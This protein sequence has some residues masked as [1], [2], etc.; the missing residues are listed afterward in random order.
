MDMFFV[1]NGIIENLYFRFLLFVYK[2][3][4][5]LFFFFYWFVLMKFYLICNI[6]FFVFIKYCFLIC[7][8][9]YF[10]D[11]ILN[12]LLLFSCWMM[13][14]KKIELIKFFFLLKIIIVGR[15]LWIFGFIWYI[16]IYVCFFRSIDVVL[17]KVCY[18]VKFLLFVFKKMFKRIIGD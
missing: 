15:I 10:D 14:Y 18:R 2:W 1:C 7:F 13:V 3:I 6:M 11:I 16:S 9:K 4:K 17:F 12:I 8:M 5:C